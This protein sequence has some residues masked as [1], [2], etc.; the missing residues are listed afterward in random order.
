[1]NAIT[2]T[3]KFWNIVSAIAILFMAGLATY[4]IVAPK[5]TE[6]QTLRTRKDNEARMV[7]QIQTIKDR[8]AATSA[9]VARYVWTVPQDRIGGQSL[10]AV[11][12]IAMKHSVRLLAFRPQKAT[13]ENGLTRLPYMVVLDGTFPSVAAMLRDLETT[14]NKLAVNLV[15]IASADASTD[16]VNATIGVIAYTPTTPTVTSA[17]TVKVTHA[18]KA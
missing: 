2:L 12:N 1:M 8:L 9:D 10:A 6:H 17:P 5:P 11:T 3:E 7:A 4:D 18:K 13:D 15:Q 14:S 16:Q